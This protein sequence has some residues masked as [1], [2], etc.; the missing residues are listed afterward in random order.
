MHKS[1]QIIFQLWLKHAERKAHK[2]YTGQISP[3]WG[4]LAEYIY[5]EIISVYLNDAE[6][7]L[8]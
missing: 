8:A 4:E 1:N 7:T 3:I 5:T 2:N 6:Q